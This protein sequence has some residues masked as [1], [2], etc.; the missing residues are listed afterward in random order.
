MVVL[1]G[2]TLLLGGVRLDVDNVTY[3][4]GDEVGRQLDGAMLYTFA[5]SVLYST[6]SVHTAYP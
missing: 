4:V 6:V 2:H 1:V 5:C 3:A